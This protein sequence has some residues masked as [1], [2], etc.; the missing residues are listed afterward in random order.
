MYWNNCY[1][2][3][4]KLVPVTIVIQLAQ[5]P[6]SSCETRQ[7]PFPTPPGEQC[8]HSSPP[9]CVE[10]QSPTGPVVK[11]SSLETKSRLL[12]ETLAFLSMKSWVPWV[13]S[14]ARFNLKVGAAFHSCPL[15]TSS[16]LRAAGQSR[17][18]HQSG[19][20]EWLQAPVHVTMGIPKP[21]LVWPGP[22]PELPS[23]VSSR[24]TQPQRRKERQTCS[25]KGLL[26]GHG[27]WASPV[28]GSG[29][30]P[31]APAALWQ[32][33]AACW[34]LLQLRSKV[35]FFPLE[36][37]KTSKASGGIKEPTVPSSLW[38]DWSFWSLLPRT[39][40]DL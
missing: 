3:L 33:R 24:K 15:F 5:L 28:Q 12:P 19:F 40:L 25:W 13:R 8:E 20:A 6:D 27:K 16:S 30:Q 7:G 23:L 17:A 38:G 9:A 35:S 36:K 32:G 22:L 29:S 4:L 10:G 34:G 26:S 21:S 11:E 37:A 39:V 2:N 31:A 14:G 18:K 1:D